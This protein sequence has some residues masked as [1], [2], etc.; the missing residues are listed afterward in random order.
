MQRLWLRTLLFTMLV[1]GTVL[2]LVPYALRASGIGWP[3][4]LGPARWIGLLP[5]VSGLAAIVTCFTH[6]V[7]HGRGTPAPYDP[8]REL[9]VAGLYRFVRNPQYVGVLLVAVGEALLAESAILL[10]YSAFLAVAYHLFVRYYEE[11]TLGRLFGEPYTR[12]R[13]VVPRWLP[14]WRVEPR[15][16]TDAGSGNV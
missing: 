12:Y 1:P 16:A 4:H 7:R 9:V 8:P 2:V 5:L 13:E 11:P 6:F 15:E 10:G 14:R 3:L